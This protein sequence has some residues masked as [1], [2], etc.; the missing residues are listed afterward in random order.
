MDEGLPTLQQGFRQL[1]EFELLFR[2]MVQHRIREHLDDLDRNTTTFLLGKEP[3]VEVMIE[4]LRDAHAEV[5]YKLEA[6]LRNLQWE[7]SMANFAVLEEFM[8]RI[9]WAKSAKQEWRYFMSSHKGTLWPVKFRWHALLTKIE[10]DIAS[11]F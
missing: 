1:L 3:K 6:P 8:D 9:L 11:I 4:N 5:L 7:P 2:G 10:H